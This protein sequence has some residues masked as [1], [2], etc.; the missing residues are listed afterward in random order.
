MCALSAIALAISFLA[1][2]M[3]SGPISGQSR[4]VITLATM[5]AVLLAGFC[6]HLGDEPDLTALRPSRHHDSVAASS[7]ARSSIGW[8]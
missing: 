4:G 7:L 5:Y 2:G 6:N 3:E 8:L 1:A